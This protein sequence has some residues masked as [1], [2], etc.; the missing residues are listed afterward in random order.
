MQISFLIVE[1]LDKRLLKLFDYLHI[2]YEL[3]IVKLCWVVVV[4]VEVWMDIWVEMRK[5]FPFAWVSL[6]E[7]VEIRVQRQ[8]SAMN[9]HHIPFLCSD[10]GDGG[11][12]INYRE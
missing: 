6:M 9:Q 11:G 1:V 2:S 4:M 12:G 5:Y 7:A 8:I 3:I 10:S